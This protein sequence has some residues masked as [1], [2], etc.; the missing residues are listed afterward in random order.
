MALQHAEHHE[1]LYERDQA[2]I[3]RFHDSEKVEGDIAEFGVYKGN[4]LI[5]T[6]LLLTRM[7]SKKLVHGFDS[8]SGFPARHP[9]DERT[10]FDELYERGNITKE[11]YAAV[12][13]LQEAESSG[14]RGQHDFGD[15]SLEYVTERLKS[16]KLDNVALYKGDFKESVVKVPQAVRYAAVLMDGNLYSSYSDVLEHCWERLSVGGF[17]YLD[18]YYSLKY[19]GP[20]IAV[21]EFCAAVGTK[22]IRSPAVSG[23]FERWHL[24]KPQ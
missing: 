19:P 6:A 14:I 11:H 24:R 23:E 8:F 9:N 12:K 18:E 5:T 3:L 2:S 16:Y 20:R 7:R 15:T 1:S 22:P 13:L 4:S 10:R 17:I 21:D